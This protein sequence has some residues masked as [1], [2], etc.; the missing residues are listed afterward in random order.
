MG[1]RREEGAE[2]I[3]FLIAFIKILVFVSVGFAGL[4]AHW[5]KKYWR[6]QTENSF[7]CY[8][9]KCEIKATKASLLTF[10]ISMFGFLA[11]SPDLT[12]YT[13][14][15]AFGLGYLIDSAVNKG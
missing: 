11:T 10:A 9:L 13:A 2:M 15:S 5:L 1:R 6:K 14:W 4:W 8:L 3:E 12:M 7:K